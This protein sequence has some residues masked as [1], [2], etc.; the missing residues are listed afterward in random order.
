MRLLFLA[1]R[2][3]T[4]GGADLHLL[5]MIASARRAGAEVTVGVG[6]IGGDVRLAPDVVV[7]RVRGLGS[8]V[9]TH[10]G[11]VRLRTLVD[12][13]DVVHLQNVMN[14]QAAMTAVAPGRTLATI[15]DHRILCP[16]PGKTL[17]DGSLCA[18]PMGP[19]PCSVCLPDGEY[20]ARMLD[21]TAA[22]ER[23]LR[24]ARLVVLSTWM[25]DELATLGRRAEVVPPWVT[26][27]AE[28][29]Q[30]GDS[31]LLAGRLV[32]HKNPMLAVA[33][34]REAGRPLPLRVAGDGPVDVAEDGVESLGWLDHDRMVSELRRGRMLL[35][36]AR[37]QEPFGIVGLEALAQGTPVVVSDV[38]G[39]RDWSGHGCVRIAPGDVEAMSEAVRTLAD[40]PARALELGRAG[41][42]EVTRRF[43][44]DAL[45]PR[46][47][48]LWEMAAAGRA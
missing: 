5:Q 41:Q 48:R 17:P 19:S 15:Q 47:W 7:E 43:T 24:G 22:R 33:A 3:S 13:A 38:G 6:R 1:D 36:P 46:L 4:R 40:D 29:R 16:G 30:A 28:R 12:G 37:W 20:R 34:W 31:V 21:L 11:S 32:A 18:Q 14:P 23:A 10:S 44:R 2:L 27:G 39:T 25:A 42:R 26:P 8:A 45:E 9:A 35:F